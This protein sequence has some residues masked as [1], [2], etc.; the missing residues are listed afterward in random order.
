MHR[1]L[2]FLIEFAIKILFLPLVAGISY[3]VLKL[4]AKSQSKILL[5]IKAPGF[6]LQKLTT[7][8]PSEDMLEVAIAAFQKVYDMDADPSVPETDFVVSKSVKKYTEELKA[9]FAEKGI[10]ESDAEWLVAVK[11]GVARS[12]LASADKM[13]VPSQVREM[14]EI[15]GVRMTGKPLWY[16]LGSTNFYGYEIKVDERVLIP[17]PET[18]LLTEM[19]IRSLEEGDKVLDLCTGSGCIAVAIAKEA[20]KQGKSVTVTAA[21]IS[22]GAISVAEVNAKANGADIKFV[23][24]DF[25]AN[26]RGKFNMIVCNP[27]YIK[28]GD[29]DAL[30]SEVKDFEPLSALDGGEDGLDFYRRL[31]KDVPKKL[32]RGG[33]LLMECGQGQA[34]EIVKL[35]KKFD[36]TIIS[37]DYSDVERFVRAV[38]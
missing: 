9:I 15:A 2:N 10:D 18:E 14:D 22:A 13:L 11:S 37:R 19:A 34:Q 35:F 38:L 23:Q 26:V 8:E 1:V 24:S 4:L 7:R 17:R 21:D 20:A 27:P 3:E 36:Y 29:I 28:S 6:A 31:A 12:E 32:V 16:I 33:T 25:L 5:P 30:Q